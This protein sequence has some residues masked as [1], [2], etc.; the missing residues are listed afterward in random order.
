MICMQ[1]E[2]DESKRQKN[3]GKHGID[4]ILAME[5]FLDT[6]RLETPDD[7]KN[8]GEIRYQCIGQAQEF[9][10]LVVYTYREQTIRIISARRANHEEKKT[11]LHIA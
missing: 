3:L 9:L 5:I 1:F 2:W 7:R 4:F 11:Y 10:L 6:R 8:Y